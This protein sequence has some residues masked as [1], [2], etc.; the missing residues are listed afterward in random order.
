MIEAA[1][2]LQEPHPELQDKAGI[3]DQRYFEER[4]K[5]RL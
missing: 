4:S 2:K 1:P 5:P 3:K